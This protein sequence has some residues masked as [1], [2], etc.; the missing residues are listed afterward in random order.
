MV[1]ILYY[2][3]F[4]YSRE[5]LGMIVIHIR[6]RLKKN[7]Q[8]EKCIDSHSKQ[9]NRIDASLRRPLKLYEEYAFFKH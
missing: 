1:I 7:K 3:I 4:N 2:S 5:L 8:F 6:G 9:I